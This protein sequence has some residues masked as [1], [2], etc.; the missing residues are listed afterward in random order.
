[1]LINA[2][3]AGTRL[4]LDVGLMQLNFIPLC[5]PNA[6]KGVFNQKVIIF[7]SSCS[8]GLHFSAFHLILTIN[9]KLDSM[10]LKLQ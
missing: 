5:S 1:M 2:T 7:Q 3:C 9:G 10:F 6:C 8:E 4:T